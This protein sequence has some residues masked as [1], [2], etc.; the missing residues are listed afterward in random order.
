MPIFHHPIPLLSSDVQSSSVKIN[1]KY[2][3]SM[4]PDVT[5]EQEEQACYNYLT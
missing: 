4:R 2:E 5:V 1:F 3:Q